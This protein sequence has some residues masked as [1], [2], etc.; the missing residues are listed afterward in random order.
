MG[1]YSNC[2][3]CVN[4]GKKCKF[5]MA[6]AI[7]MLSQLE[8]LINFSQSQKNELEKCML[9]VDFS[10]ENFNPKILEDNVNNDK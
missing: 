7:S 10:C 9:K 8:Y 1:Q 2:I 5:I 6:Q 4:D 3:K